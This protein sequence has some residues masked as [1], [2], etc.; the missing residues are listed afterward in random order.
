MKRIIPAAIVAVVILVAFG[1]WWSSDTQALKRRTQSLLSTLTL[2]SGSGKVTRQMGVYSLEKLLEQQ[3]ELI[4]P[5]VDQANGTFDRGEM[6]SAYSW[7]CNQSNQTR[8]TL[9]EIESVSV[10][11]ETAQVTFTLNG[12]VELPSYRPVDGN[13]SVTF[14][15]RKSEAGWQLTRAKWDKIP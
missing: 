10:T 12:L 13:F 14:D 9:K 2:E 4:T 11:G 15:W 1:Y 8:F 5:T 3:V 6:K 7:L